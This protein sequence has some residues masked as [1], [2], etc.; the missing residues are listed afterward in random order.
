MFFLWAS[1]TEKKNKKHP[2]QTA[3]IPLEATL[4]SLYNQTKDRLCGTGET[5]LFINSIPSGD[6]PRQSLMQTLFSKETNDGRK[7]WAEVSPSAEER[8]AMGS[9]S[10]RKRGNNY[11]FTES[12]DMS[13]GIWQSHAKP[14]GRDKVALWPASFN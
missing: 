7:K 4:A 6:T 13:S 12:V 14:H 10:I 1:K 8:G 9:Y 5:S 11:Q 3:F 2:T